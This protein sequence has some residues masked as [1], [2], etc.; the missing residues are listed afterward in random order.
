[1]YNLPV[2]HTVQFHELIRSVH[3]SLDYMMMIFFRLSI[4]SWLKRERFLNCIRKF[5]SE[6][7]DRNYD[8][9]GRYFGLRL[10]SVSPRQVP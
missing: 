7:F 9:P 3:L 1:M 2:A 10:F 5:R 4:E 6:T 8:D